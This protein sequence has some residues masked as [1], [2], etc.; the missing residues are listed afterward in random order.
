MR[1][2]RSRTSLHNLFPGPLK[3]STAGTSRQTTRSG[4]CRGPA[5]LWWYS[6]LSDLHLQIGPAQINFTEFSFC[7]TSLQM[8][9]DREWAP[10]DCYHKTDGHLEVCAP[11]CLSTPSNQQDQV[12]PIHCEHCPVIL[13]QQFTS[14]CTGGID[15]LHELRL[16]VQFMLQLLLVL[17]SSS[18]NSC[19][20]QHILSWRRV[21]FCPVQ[22]NL[23]LVLSF[24]T[25]T[26][27][28]SLLPV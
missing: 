10:S 19:C 7:Q 12:S 24:T 28:F 23:L 14:K 22:V 17:P 25:Q 20:W 8:A 11:A 2:L 15:F 4:I 26:D 3:C 16:W 6:D 18:F 1:A 27:K 9:N 21:F 5:R 13:F